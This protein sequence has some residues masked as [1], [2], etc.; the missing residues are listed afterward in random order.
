LKTPKERKKSGTS[1]KSSAKN[2]HALAEPR[3]EV[4]EIGEAPAAIVNGAAESAPAPSA[5]VH[6]HVEMVE[7]APMAAEPANGVDRP[8]E[9]GAESELARE[10]IE[11]RAYELYLKRGCAHGHHL[12]DWLAAERE[13]KAGRGAGATN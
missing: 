5:L 10:M 2:K 13:L 9:P 6:A 4:A 3:K 8:P 11:V 12:E 1:R 7:P